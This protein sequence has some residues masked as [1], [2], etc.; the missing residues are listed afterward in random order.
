MF[1]CFHFES[2]SSSKL[3]SVDFAAFYFTARNFFFCVSFEN[4]ASQISFQWNGIYG[5]EREKEQ[6]R[7]SKKNWSG[8]PLNGEGMDADNEMPFILP[9]HFNLICILQMVFCA[10]HLRHQ[11]EMDMK[12]NTEP[13]NISIHNFHEDELACIYHKLIA[14]FEALS[15]NQGR[16]A[17]FQFLTLIFSLDVSWRA[18][19]ASAQSSYQ[20]SNSMA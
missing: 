1:K 12:K 13:N 15:W 6:E 18:R 9:N 11:R 10:S 5:T 8:K 17:N 4:W 20:E 16:L 2:I 3:F 14:S 19:A 7:E